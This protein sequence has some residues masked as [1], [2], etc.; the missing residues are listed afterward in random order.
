[1]GGDRFLLQ[2]AL[3]GLSC[4]LQAVNRRF[5]RSLLVG[6]PIG[7]LG[8]IKECG[9]S[10]NCATL[11]ANEM[12]RVDPGPYE[13]A[14]SALSLH[15][16]N[17]L[18]GVITQIRN[19]L[20]PDGLFLA[21]MFGGDTLQELRESF[22]SAEVETIGGLSPRVSPFANVRELG[23]LLQRAG[24]ALTVA[25]VERTTVLYD[26]FSDLV[27]DLRTHGE[28]NALVE[29]TRRPMSRKLFSALLDH[30]NSHYADSKARLRAT[31]DLVYLTGWVPH[32]SQ[33]KPL[34][35][36]SAKSRLIDAL[37]A[38]GGRKGEH[39]ALRSER[40]QKRS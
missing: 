32:E 33:P 29:R 16:I 40:I 17:D 25:D 22:A 11:N 37:H 7:R 10:W 15:A 28:T 19:T 6:L 18:P 21:A 12:L 35:P 24:F 23:D 20:S 38:A 36:G 27:R 31:F 3:E 8:N 39:S 1:M 30:Y 9:N 14:L 2:E 13:L 5:D 4:R 26:N 34:R